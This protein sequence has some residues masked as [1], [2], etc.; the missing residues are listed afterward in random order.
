[1]KYLLLAFVLFW[2][3]FISPMYGDVCKFYPSCSEYGLEA[4]RLHG[5]VR[6]SWLTV[7]RI[8][9]CHPWSLGGV[10]PVPG[11]DLEARLREHQDPDSADPHAVIRESG[12]GPGAQPVRES[13]RGPRIYVR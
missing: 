5:A 10:D 6:G 11:S 3:R 13:R 2:R 9:R 7:R 12:P 1:M 8:A 4:L